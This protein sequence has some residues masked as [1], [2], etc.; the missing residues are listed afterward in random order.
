M[1]RG[2]AYAGK[3]DNEKA[4]QD[5]KRV[6]F[7]DS[8]NPVAF[9]AIGLLLARQG[10][11]QEGIANCKKA[12]ELAPDNGHSHN[13]LAWLLAICPDPILR[14]GAEALKQAKKACELT[15]WEDSHC[16]GTLAAAYAETGDFDK[17]VKW[18]TKRLEA[19]MPKSEREE[20][21]KYLKL[22]KEKQTITS[23]Q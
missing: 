22:Y 3:N 10:N 2:E 6:I 13:N 19:V 20:G 15:K 21:E 7:L 9:S 11:Y 12:V 16:L 18:Q 1:T 5:Y 8:K 14:N 17:A 23:I 4:I